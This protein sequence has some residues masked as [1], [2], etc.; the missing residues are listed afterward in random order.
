MTPIEA[1]PLINNPIHHIIF[2]DEWVVEDKGGIK[3][4]HQKKL[5]V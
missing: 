5:E 2:K 1:R 3:Y 4:I